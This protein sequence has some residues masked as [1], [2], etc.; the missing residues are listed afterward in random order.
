MKI[1]KSVFIFVAI[2]LFVQLWQVFCFGGSLLIVSTTY[3]HLLGEKTRVKVI[4]LY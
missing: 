3:I 4:V 1:K 2:S